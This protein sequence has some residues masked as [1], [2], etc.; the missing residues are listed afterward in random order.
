[1]LFEAQGWRLPPTIK[2]Q[3]VGKQNQIQHEIASTGAPEEQKQATKEADRLQLQ[4]QQIKHDAPD[5]SL[6]IKNGKK[7]PHQQPKRRSENVLTPPNHKKAKKN[8]NASKANSDHK[9]PVRNDVDEK[10]QRQPQQNQGEDEKKGFQEEEEGPTMIKN[11]KKE[12]KRKEATK[13]G[14][15]KRLQKMLKEKSSSAPQP[16]DSHTRAI[17]DKKDEQHTSIQRKS[18]TTPTKLTPLQQKMREKL[19]GARFRWLNEQLYTAPGDVSFK[20][21]QEK[22]ELFDEYHSGFRHQVESWPENPVDIFV[23]QLAKL[24]E[25]TVIADLGCGDAKIAHTLKKQKVLSFDMVAKNDKV[26]PCDIS[27]LPL[28]ENSVDVAVFSLALMGTN[29]IDFLKEAKRVLKP[30]GELKIAEVVSRF[31]DIDGF[32]DM[33]EELGFEFLEKDTGNTMFVMLYFAKQTTDVEQEINEEMLQG[34]TKK[35]KRALKKGA[36]LKTSTAKLEKRAASLLKPC[37]YKKR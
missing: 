10:D 27:K 7:K 24:P 21:F 33:L 1:M 25:G 12:N 2:P 6:N 28:P 22:P 5:S 3:T 23:S 30:G 29:Y 8:R 17:S 34:L 32:I 15:K 9:Q 37:L 18:P 31:S 14:L 11:E 26:V 13:K 19:T 16:E 36:G 20:L 4:I 35:Q